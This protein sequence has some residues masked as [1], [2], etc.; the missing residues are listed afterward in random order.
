MIMGQVLQA[1]VGQIPARQA[2]VAGGI[3]MD[4]PAVTINKVCLSGLDAIALGRPAD[5]GRRV[6]RSWSPAAWN[7]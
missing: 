3:A 4:V 7:P 1:G 5:P 2:A 6:Q